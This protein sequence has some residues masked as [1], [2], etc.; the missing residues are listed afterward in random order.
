MLDSISYDDKS[1]F[2][3]RVIKRYSNRKLYDTRSSRYVTL[4]QIAQMVRAGEDVQIIDNRTKEDKT[5]VTLALIISEQLKNSPG[6]IPL[7][8]LRALIRHDSS[9]PPPSGPVSSTENVVDGALRAPLSAAL[10]FLQEDEAMNPAN[11]DLVDSKQ[12]DSKHNAELPRDAEFRLEQWRAAL[13][14]KVRRLPDPQALQMLQGQVQSLHERLAE[15]ERRLVSKA[16]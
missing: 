1:G 16:E 6:G 15:L 4:P 14:E 12:G 2:E 3:F 7:G 9:P 10:Q 13:E 11:R 5:E 8:T